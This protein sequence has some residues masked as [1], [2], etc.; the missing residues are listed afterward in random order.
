MSSYF[1]DDDDD[2]Y[3][4][5]NVSVD[6]NDEYVV[7]TTS[8]V[9]NKKKY[10]PSLVENLNDDDVQEE[11]DGDDDADEDNDIQYG[12]VDDIVL[13]NDIDDNEHD[14]DD[15][16]DVSIN[17]EDNNTISGKKKIQ[18]LPTNLNYISN[19]DEEYDDDD[20]ND[21]E[22]YLKKFDKEINKNYIMDFHPECV[23]H[24]YDEIE[25][26]VKTIRDKNGIIIDDLH[27][28]IPFLTKY[29]RTRILGQRAKQ[30]NSGATPFVKVP[31]NVIDGYVI[32]E[33]ELKQK[34]IPFIIKRP[35]PNGG[36][37]YWYVKDLENI[38]F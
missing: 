38:S 10:I 1:N 28:T 26:L 17:E 11:E 16:D 21:G 31:D 24:N 35:L 9:K 37:E 29:E 22:V 30:I 20:D 19:E 8:T 2:A 15:D 23:N 27:K 18:Q 12:G 3:N 34:R 36:S 32:A 7:S 4:S 13:E 25:G 33:I 6:D 5:D 14:D